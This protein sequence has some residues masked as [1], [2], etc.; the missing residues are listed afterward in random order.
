MYT[1]S[2]DSYVYIVHA[3]V[4]TLMYSTITV[5]YNLFVGDIQYIASCIVRCKCDYPIVCIIFAKYIYDWC[6]ICV[7]LVLQVY[8]M[9]VIF[10]CLKMYVVMHC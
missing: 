8:I 1:A 3:C 7:H 9:C 10:V 4:C 2:N 5:M 6:I